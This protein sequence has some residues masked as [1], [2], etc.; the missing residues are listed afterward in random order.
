MRKFAI[1]LII[2]C[3]G[4]WMQRAAAA[5]LSYSGCWQA[6]NT[7]NILE[8]RLT[9]FN[10]EITFDNQ[11][12]LSQET[13]QVSVP[14]IDP[15]YFSISGD[16]NLSGVSR[17]ADSLAFQ[18][19]IN[20]GELKKI[21]IEPWYAPAG[22]WYFVAYSD[23]QPSSTQAYDPVHEEIINQLAIINPYF[24]IIAGDL[25]SGDSSAELQTIN[26]SN[27]LNLMH[28]TTASWFSVPGNHDVEAGISLYEQYIGP[29][30]YSFDFQNTHFTA[31]S[32]EETANPG[33][34]LDPEYS[35]LEY[36]LSTTVN[37]EHKIC[38]WHRPLV[39]ASWST[40]SVIL[41][42]SNALT[43]TNLLQNQGVELLFSG[44][45]HGY[46]AQDLGGFQ[47]IISGGAGGNINQPNGKNN[48]ILF[49]VNTTDITP[50]VIYTDEFP[51]H[52]TEYNNNDGTEEQ[53]TIMVYNDSAADWPWVRLKFKVT[54]DIQ[55]PYAYDENGDY[56]NFNR[57]VFADYQV[58]YIETDITADSTKT[59]YFGKNNLL[60]PGLINTIRAN[61][62]VSYN[63]QP[64]SIHTAV[65][66]TATP[67]EDSS[68]ITLGN[69][70]EATREWQEKA[71]SSST[72]TNYQLSN[73]A[74][75][76]SYIVFVND[77]IYL[78]QYTDNSGNLD[79]SYQGIERRRNFKVI[80]DPEW[81][82]TELLT[83][84]AQ[85]GGPQVQRYN[86]SGEMLGQFFAYSE[87]NIGSY[88]I[89]NADING[90]Q[91]GEII[92][93]PSDFY[94]SQMKVFTAEGIE[95]AQK[96]LYANDYRNGVNLEFADIDGNGKAEILAAKKNGNRIKLLRYSTENNQI[97]EILETRIYASDF[98]GGIDIKTA[99]IDGDGSL[100]IIASPDSGM[101]PIKIFDWQNGNLHLSAKLDQAFNDYSGVSLAA[102]D[103][104]KD[105][106]A[107]I[108]I[109]PLSG[110]ENVRVKAY[111]ITA[112]GKFKLL[113]K[114]RAAHATA[115]SGL[116]IYSADINEDYKAELFASSTLYPEKIY[117][118]QYQ[119]QK[120]TLMQRIK[121]F[122][123]LVSALQISFLDLD[124]DTSAELYVNSGL[125]NPP[126]IKVYKQNGN[127]LERT[128]NFNAYTAMFTGGLNFNVD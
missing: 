99:D 17:D 125:N 72:V 117:I 118:Y 128:T 103:L 58:A 49:N 22:D 26:F 52:L 92:T 122:T 37:S 98:T 80:T 127:T 108:M 38:F 64:V 78:K 36:D 114:K 100:E 43:L 31:A 66:L 87:S 46:D 20:A 120:F 89:F 9:S 32:T 35:W 123:E 124:Q 28:N 105:G 85:H 77:K 115:F 50:Q 27:F 57:Q 116:K 111:R 48:Y 33:S 54:S 45:N 3:S 29:S 93:L 101:A 51:L 83:I 53:S 95:L 67:A 39:P 102:A 70:S 97:K 75:N 44:H 119:K 13:W 42:A 121:P 86:Q 88:E 10:C 84:P 96:N 55:N 2:I 23:P 59:I 14:F 56:L 34:I 30:Y 112:T 63:S 4:I 47:Q 18:T 62:E 109:A 65:N 61:G 69:W 74:S 5:N 60:Q 104:N 12:G 41:E 11:V 25:T 82:A 15:D 1:L 107:E 106:K 91:Q 110:T 73:L 126:K 21:T 16:D 94:K 8:V 68:I 24:S 79:F 6:D 113:T 81:H 40:S 90:D 7:N 19:T 76:K 71:H